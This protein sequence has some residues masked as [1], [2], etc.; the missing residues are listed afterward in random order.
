MPVILRYFTSF[1]TFH[2][3]PAADSCSEMEI[4]ERFV[5]CLFGSWNSFALYNHACW[6]E[7]FYVWYATYFRPNKNKYIKKHDDNVTVI[8]ELHCNTCIKWLWRSRG[9][10]RAFSTQVRGFKPSR[11]HQIFK[12]EKILS[13]PSFGGEVKPSVPCCRFAARKRFLYGMEVII[14]AKLPD[15]I[16]RPQFHLSLLGSLASLWTWRHLATKVG[17][18]KGGESNGNLLLRA[19]TGCSMPEPYQL[20]DWALVPAEPA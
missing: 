14:L 10:V 2:C 11:S 13:T 9:S 16:S 15:N 17:T 19:C 4:V 20:P 7:N 1:S 8:Y 18:S 6:W 3:L 5:P 12:G